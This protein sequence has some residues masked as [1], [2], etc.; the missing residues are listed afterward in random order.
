VAGC[1]V[2][3]SFFRSGWRDSNANTPLYQSGVFSGRGH[4]VDSSVSERG[5]LNYGHPAGTQAKIA[6]NAEELPEKAMPHN[7]SRGV[8]WNEA[9]LEQV[10]P[11]SSRLKLFAM[12]RT[13]QH[14]TP[15]HTTPPWHTHTHTHKP[16]LSGSF[17]PCLCAP[18]RPCAGIVFFCPCVPDKVSLQCAAA[19]LL[20]FRSCSSLWISPTLFHRSARR[21]HR[22]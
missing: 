9:N 18:G 15:H 5:G 2:S 7:S 14:T 4:L 17:G 8:H 16:H 11:N 12:R 22:A 6:S 10:L 1:V 3:V 21:K 13:P 20:S 19:S